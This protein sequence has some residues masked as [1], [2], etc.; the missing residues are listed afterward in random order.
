MCLTLSTI[1]QKRPEKPITVYKFYPKPKRG[2][3]NVSSPY[4]SEYKF[5]L[6]KGR[7]IKS[8]RNNTKLECDEQ[9]SYEVS[10]G[11]HVFLSKEGA[12]HIGNKKFWSGKSTIA[13]FTG[14]PEDFVATGLFNCHESAVFTKLRFEGLEESS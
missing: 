4:F 5:R 3:Y 13:K 12:I 11:L 1:H 7:F 9:S 10:F 8:N 2:K 14:Y 6:R